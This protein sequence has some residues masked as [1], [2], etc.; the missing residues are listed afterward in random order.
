MVN[1]KKYIYLV[2]ICL[3][4]IT[5][6]G[7]KSTKTLKCS[8]FT[9]EVDKSYVKEKLADY[10]LY[11][12][13]NVSFIVA[14]KDTKESIIKANHDFDSMSFE[15]FKKFFCKNNGIEEVPLNEKDNLNYFDYL[16]KA[17]GKQYWFRTFVFKTEDAF[18]VCQFGCLFTER[19]NYEYKF[20]DWAK[21]ISFK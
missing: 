16:K 4:T 18:W 15:E 11:A 12:Y 5:L 3:L 14:I 2:I 7:C 19:A 21:T 17:E 13:N 20:I 1:M 9:M 8:G 10:E 6:I